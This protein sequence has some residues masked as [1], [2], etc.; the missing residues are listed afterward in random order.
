MEA[1]AEKITGLEKE[2]REKKETDQQSEYD[3]A[4]KEVKEEATKKEVNVD[5]LHEKLV[6]LENLSRKTNQAD[7]EKMSMILRRFHAHKS[8][9]SFVAAL[10][11]K[12]VA[13][14]EE[15][16]ILE[17]EQKLLKYFKD[18][19]DKPSEKEK[20]TAQAHEGMTPINWKLGPYSLMPQF[21]AHMPLQMPPM[22]PMP[23]LTPLMRSAS[24]MHMKG[25]RQG[26]GSK[27]IVCYKCRKQGHIIRNCPN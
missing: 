12:L 16:V 15:E 4:K 11:L 20:P 9:P 2:L 19:T 6:T 18:Q 1:L 21:P 14:K 5:L 25:N 26:A 23:P 8:K 24:N 17:K 7:K 10:I 22:P 3:K 13:S 27:D